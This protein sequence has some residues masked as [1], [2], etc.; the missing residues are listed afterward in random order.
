M[1]NEFVEGGVSGWGEWPAG[2]PAS[3]GAEVGVWRRDRGNSGIDPL[4][5]WLGWGILLSRKNKEYCHES[6]SELAV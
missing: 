6:T 5:G 1:R 2:R 4:C 3:L